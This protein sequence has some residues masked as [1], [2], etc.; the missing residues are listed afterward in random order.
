MGTA[1]LGMPPR[2]HHLSDSGSDP[3]LE[4]VG[5]WFRLTVAVARQAGLGEAG[6]PPSGPSR[7]LVLPGLCTAFVQSPG[8]WVAEVLLILGCLVVLWMDVEAFRCIQ[9]NRSPTLDSEPHECVS[10]PLDRSR[11]RASEGARPA[12]LGEV[13]LYLRFWKMGHIWLIPKVSH[14]HSMFTL[15]HVLCAQHITLPICTYEKL[16]HT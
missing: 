2:V 16:A 11:G 9:L 8:K 7:P 4:S 15:L 3:L 12:G 13:G 5:S 6:R 10:W 1:S 14:G